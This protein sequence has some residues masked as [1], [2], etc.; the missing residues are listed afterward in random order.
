MVAIAKAVSLAYKSN[1]T[2]CCLNRVFLVIIVWWSLVIIVIHHSN[3]GYYPFLI[4]MAVVITMVV[5]FF[6]L[7][8][9]HC[10]TPLFYQHDS[11]F[12]M[13][14]IYLEG[15]T[16]LMSLPLWWCS[17]GALCPGWEMLW[18]HWVPKDM[19]PSR[20]CNSSS[21]TS[22]HLCTHGRGKPHPKIRSNCFVSRDFYLQSGSP[23]NRKII[24]FTGD[25]G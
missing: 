5:I 6:T 9:L 11:P 12:I 15:V 13:Q 3:V 2:S 25:H 23:T 10:V 17:Y 14:Q 20:S 1:Q 16:Q 7:H 4:N 24:R 19:G 21:R 22:V 8:Q 18:I